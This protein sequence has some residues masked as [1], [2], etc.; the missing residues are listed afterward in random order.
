MK[1]TNEFDASFEDI[2]DFFILAAET[3]IFDFEQ[4]S[5]SDFIG[6]MKKHSKIKSIQFG[7][8]DPE[9]IKELERL[10]SLAFSMA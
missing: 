5:F 2:G 8:R 9:F 7:S 3:G 4:V 10:S 1:N 6:F